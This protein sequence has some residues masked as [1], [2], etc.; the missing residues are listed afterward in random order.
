M[1]ENNIEFT[2]MCK[3]FVATN[4]MPIIR[5][6]DDGIKRRI[7]LVPFDVKISEKDQDKQLFEKLR[8]ETPGI[9]AWAVKGCLAWQKHGLKV[10]EVVKDAT[11]SYQNDM[12]VMATFI[13]EICNL[14]PKEKVK[15]E[16]LYRRYS[17]WCDENEE[18]KQPLHAFITYLKERGCVKRRQSEGYF[19][20][21]IGLK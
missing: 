11:A 12:D 19:W 14:G 2:P 15:S 10:P 7:K 4:H 8:A 3:I 18:F 21:G 20:Y 17:D 6:M 16:R 9:L 13:A 5:G 1:Y